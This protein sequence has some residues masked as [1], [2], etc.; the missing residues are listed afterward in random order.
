MKIRISISLLPCL[1]LLLISA[2]ANAEKVVGTCKVNVVGAHP[3]TIDGKFYEGK[4]P[5]NTIRSFVSTRTWAHKWAEEY[6][7]KAALI[8]DMKSKMA[9][10]LNSALTIMCWSDKGKLHMSPVSNEKAKSQDFPD[11][12]KKYR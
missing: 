12:P 7:S 4:V 8:A 6:R 3:F 10:D 11:A 5:D 2:Q 9:D 1:A